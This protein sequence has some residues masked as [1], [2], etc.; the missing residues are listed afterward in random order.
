[1][2]RTA[3]AQTATRAATMT[4]MRVLFKGTSLA[5]LDMRQSPALHRLVPRAYV[6]DSLCTLPIAR[7][8]SVGRPSMVEEI[9]VLACSRSALIAVSIGGAAVPLCQGKGY[10]ASTAE[11]RPLSLGVW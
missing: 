3:T 8:V 5:F 2:N 4:S 10:R 6:S 1:M 7:Q 11:P 9:S